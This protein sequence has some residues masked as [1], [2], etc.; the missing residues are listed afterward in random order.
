MRQVVLGIEI[1]PTWVVHELAIVADAEVLEVAWV[2]AAVAVAVAAVIDDADVI[3][4]WLAFDA[5]VVVVGAVV[6]IVS[7][8]VVI[9]GA[10]VIAVR[11]LDVAVRG[12][13]VIL[14]NLRLLR[15]RYRGCIAVSNS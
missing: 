12:D 3:A 5:A 15:L 2:G 4:R 6:V 10:V 8:V 9:V 1:V 13:V 14:G 7:A 11:C